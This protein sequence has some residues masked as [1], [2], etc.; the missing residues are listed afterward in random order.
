MIRY[1]WSVDSDM[2]K[3][4]FFL[5]PPQPP[6]E[7]TLKASRIGDEEMELSSAIDG[8]YSPINPKGE[9]GGDGDAE[10]A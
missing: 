6:T 8:G 7:W 2:N 5:D 9:Q 3:K 10:Q 4:L 1:E